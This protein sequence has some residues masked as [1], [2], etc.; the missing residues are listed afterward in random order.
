MTTLSEYLVSMA[1]L[2]PVKTKVKSALLEEGF[3]NQVYLISWHDRPRL[4]LRVPGLDEAAFNI[5][6]QNEMAILLSAAKVGLSPSVYW[7]D[8]QGAFACPFVEQ[9][10][11][12]WDVT[13]STAS[14]HK[15]ASALKRVHALPKV[16]RTFCIY[17]LIAHYL[18]S[19]ECLLPRRQDL[20]EEFGYVRGLF[21]NLPRVESNQ[22]PVLC[23][24]DLNPKNVLM[25]DGSFWLIDWECAGMGDPLF[26]LAVVARSHNLTGLQQIRLIQAYDDS[27]EVETTLDK[28]AQYSLAYSLRE[29]VWLLLKY[30]TTPNDATAWS[31]YMDFKT[32]PSLNPF[33]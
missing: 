2:L 1:S 11:L 29:M 3:S 13:H 31:S 23:H 6:R 28:I 25:D 10:S 32:R 7:H 20:Q 18:Q 30:L 24:N 12:S 27:L 19:V 26:D 9:P 5:D 4:V 22:S 33:L 14:L 21:M 17:A 8:E 16:S 15:M